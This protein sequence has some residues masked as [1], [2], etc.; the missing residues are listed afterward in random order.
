MSTQLP[1]GWTLAASAFNWSPELMVADRTSPE[2]A[3]S[4]GASGVA[5]VIELEAAQT[6]RTFP[7]PT[8]AETSSIRS[9]LDATDTSVSIVGASLDDWLTATTRR[10][11]DERYEFLLPQL[12][13]AERLG[14][15]GIRLPLGQAGPALLERLLPRLHEHGLTLYEELQGQQS[16]D[17]PQNAAAVEAVAAMDD[18]S[19]R[20]L[21]DISMLMPSLPPSYLARLRAGGVDASLVDALE[22]DWRSP[23]TLDAVQASLRG[24]TVPPQ[25]HTLFMNLVIRFGRSDARELREILPLVGG[26]HLKFWDLDDTGGRISNPIREIS[27][28]LAAVG[29]TGTLCSEWGGHEWIDS[30]TPEQ[31]TRSHLALAREAI[32]E[33]AS[34]SAPA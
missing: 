34:T 4:I 11:E 33:G 19:I 27:A 10:S 18:T 3:A 25:V 31:A 5:N 22:H 12:R 24:G 7:D 2:I 8:D 15:E 21:L 29:F 30:L 13:A 20:L 28:E 1:E 26:V 14:A 17:K 32:S 16:L 6:W 23:A 9:A